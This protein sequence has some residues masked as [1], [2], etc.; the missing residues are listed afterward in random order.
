[1]KLIDR[2]CGTLPIQRVGA[3]VFLVSLCFVFAWQFEHWF[4]PMDAARELIGAMKLGRYYRSD[5]HWEARGMLLGL[6]LRFLAAPVLKWI[7][8]R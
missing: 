5:L 4:N 2:L 8:G 1:M 6:F 3:L 7:R